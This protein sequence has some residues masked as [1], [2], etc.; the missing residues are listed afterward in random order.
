MTFAILTNTG[1]N[2]EAAALAAGQALIITEIAWGDGSRI[3]AGGETALENEQGRKPVQGSGTVPDTPNTAFFEI[4]L[5]E[6]EGPFVIQEVGLFDEDGDMIAVAHYDPPVSKP[7]DHVSA[8][9]RTNILFS[10]LENLILKVQS[11]DAYVPVERKIMTNEGI[12]GGGDMSEDRTLALDFASETQALA[13]T[14]TTKVMTPQRV[15]QA[16]QALVMPSANF[17]P[18]GGY[19]RLAGGLIIQWGYMTRYSEIMGVT[20][21]I[22]FPNRVHTV[23]VQ[24]IDDTHNYQN[25]A[26]YPLYQTSRSVFTVFGDDAADAFT[27][28]AIG[29]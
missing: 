6:N 10:D 23:Q 5:D 26:V 15:Y 19:A 20:Y 24:M 8:L 13:G 22:T 16:I 9:I 11:T 27:W 1:R 7:K 25:T 4:L 12:T 21:P 2:K 18:S 3:P 14:N 17:A 29:S 28:L